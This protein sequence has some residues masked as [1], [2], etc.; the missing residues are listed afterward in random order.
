M[1]NLFKYLIAIMFIFTLFSAPVMANGFDNDGISSSGNFNIS[2]DAGNSGHQGDFSFIPNG[3]SWGYGS[4]YGAVEGTAKGGV[5]IG[6]ASADL[7]ITG[8]GIAGT[9][10]FH[11]SPQIEGFDRAIG[12]GVLSGSQ[13]E[14]YIG[15][16]LDTSASFLAGAGGLFSGEGCEFTTNGSFLGSSPLSM[17]DSRGMTSGLAGQHGSGSF[18]G[19][20]LSLFAG[21]TDLHMSIDIIG[22]SNS[23]SGRFI[24]WGEDGSKTEGMYTHVTAGTTVDVIGYANRECFSGS[25]YNGSYN[26]AGGATTMTMQNLN[27]GYASGTAN[28]SYQG[29]GNLNHG[30]SGS[31]DGYSGTSITT[32]PGMQGGFSSAKAGMSVSVGSGSVQ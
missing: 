17:W 31:V 6:R 3:W 25:L 16:S 22:S 24:G 28:G 13:A 26:V 11:F 30:F 10:A 5:W 27:N 8:G 20:S 14:T 12:I 19:G 21:D 2:V 18:E 1:K 32:V 4:G 23:Q 7:K 15:G 29:T 9:E